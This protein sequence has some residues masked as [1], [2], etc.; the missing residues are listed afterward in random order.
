MNT[1]T[2]TV[3]K[4]NEET[5]KYKCIHEELIQNHSLEITEMKS[6]LNYKKE[7]LDDLKKQNEKMQDTLEEIKEDI[8]KIMLKSKDGDTELN[9]RIIKL[10]NQNQTLQQ[11]INEIKTTQDKNTDRQ[12]TKIALLISAI[13][14]IVSIITNI[15]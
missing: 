15:T 14:I 4:M 13:A 7:K 3:M 10:E 11:E 1:N 2:K 9:Q 5:P 6:E 8:N 12:Y